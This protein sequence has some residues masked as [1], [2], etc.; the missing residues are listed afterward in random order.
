MWCDV[1]TWTLFCMQ[2]GIS[3]YVM[4]TCRHYLG[5]GLESPPIRPHISLQ[6]ER[7]D[8]WMMVNS[9]LRQARW[10][11]Q[12]SLRCGPPLLS[13]LLWPSHPLN[14]AWTK[15]RAGSPLVLLDS[16]AMTKNVDGPQVLLNTFYHLLVGWG[17]GAIPLAFTV[18][19]LSLFDR[20]QV[21][22]VRAVK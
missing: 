6:H 7:A 3:T 14:L 5:C 2:L 21:H 1:D 12:Y 16:L 8:N 22:K 17:W 10:A 4:M 18:L 13:H 9:V 19:L 15:K 20:R 11:Q